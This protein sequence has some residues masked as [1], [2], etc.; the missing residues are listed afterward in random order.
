MK[1]TLAAFILGVSLSPV[2]AYAH[3]GIIQIDGPRKAV[4]IQFPEGSH[5]DQFCLA[6]NNAPDGP[7]LS[8]RHIHADS[9]RCRIWQLL[10]LWE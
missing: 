10:D 9:Y 4:H 1:K 8:V 7:I 6:Y 5:E 3:R 2:A